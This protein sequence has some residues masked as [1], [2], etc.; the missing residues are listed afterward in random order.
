M[1]K[2]LHSNTTLALWHEIIYQ[3]ENSCEIT[4]KQEL[5]SYLV[6][7][8]IRF[9]NK[10]QIIKQIMAVDFLKGL[11]LTQHQKEA[12][13]QEVGDK[14][15]IFSGL[16][17]QNS[18]KRLVRPSYFVKLGQSAYLNISKNDNDIYA[19]LSD[20]FVALMDVLQSIRCY[21]KSYPDL[22]PIKAYELWEETGSQRAFSILKQ[23][24]SAIP[25]LIREK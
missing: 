25:L 15:L 11:K 16:F 17:P 4:L 2:L 20:E 23:Y 12:A 1:A 6:F 5:E 19:L 24:T 18:E 21:S 13:L 10:P 22:L 9:T 3:A 7:L 8:L 14:C